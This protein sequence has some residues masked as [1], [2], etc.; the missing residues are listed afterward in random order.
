MVKKAPKKNG[1]PVEWTDEKLLKLGKELLEYVK[2]PKVWHISSFEVIEKGFH[3]GWLKMIASRHPSFRAILDSAQSIL[4]NRILESAMR[5]EGNQ[6]V[7]TTLTPHYLK[8]IHEV[9]ESKEDRKLQRQ[10]NLEKYKNEL[11]NKS[12]DEA[13]AKIDKMD[14]SISLMEKLLKYEKILKEHELLDE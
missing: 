5:G 1:R 8:D 10:M 9:T 14:L 2:N 7:I 13:E 6:W 12:Q 4:G 3:P 11:G